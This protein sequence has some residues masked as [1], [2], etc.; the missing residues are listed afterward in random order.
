VNERM[1]VIYASA[2]EKRQSLGWLIELLSPP[3][4]RTTAVRNV[5]PSKKVD[6]SEF[7]LS[8][9]AF[10][11]THLLVAKVECHEVRKEARVIAWNMSARR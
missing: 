8:W 5:E 9:V 6:T 7:T 11:S 4:L 1:T 2:Q 3:S 10:L